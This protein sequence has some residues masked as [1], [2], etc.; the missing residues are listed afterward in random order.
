MQQLPVALP[1]PAASEDGEA[2]GTAKSRGKGDK[3]YLLITCPTWWSL[4]MVTGLLRGW[5]CCHLRFIPPCAAATSLLLGRGKHGVGRIDIVENR[6]VG[7]KS[8]GEQS[9][10]GSAVPALKAAKQGKTLVGCSALA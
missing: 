8:R 7:M 4:R 2:G 1:A 5:P 6:F 10:D 9:P 3:I